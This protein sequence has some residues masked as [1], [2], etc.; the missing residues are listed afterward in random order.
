M[1]TSHLRHCFLTQPV[2]VNSSYVY[3]AYLDDRLAPDVDSKALPVVRVFTGLP[4][5][6]I[7]Q[8]R[9]N[10]YCVFWYNAVDLPLVMPV[11]GITDLDVLDTTHRSVHL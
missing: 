4:R 9:R 6:A 1:T 2:E 3:S 11:A 7:G 5:N 10:W 8:A